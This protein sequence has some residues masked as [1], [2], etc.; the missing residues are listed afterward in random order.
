MK[1]YPGL[2]NPLTGQTEPLLL[3]G[4][5]P[6]VGVEGDC[7]T[8]E[9]SVIDWTALSDALDN[10]TVKARVLYY[11]L[12]KGIILQLNEL[13]RAGCPSHGLQIALT[14]DRQSHKP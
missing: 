5:P 9:G 8:I 7:I 13:D 11:A 2:P 4:V 12:G 14:L 6:N 1:H 10:G 3:N